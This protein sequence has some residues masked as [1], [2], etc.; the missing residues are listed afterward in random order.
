[1]GN[2]HAQYVI[3]NSGWSAIKNDIYSAAEAVIG[4]QIG[5]IFTGCSGPNL[6]LDVVL[7]AETVILPE[8]LP[9]VV[10]VVVISSFLEQAISTDTATAPAIKRKVFFI[11][12]RVFKFFDEAKVVQE[13][14][15]LQA[16]SM[17][18]TIL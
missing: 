10:V 2:G 14:L 16:K 3:T 18:S 1:M 11:V 4:K 9:V 13:V 6:L 7:A 12:I 15:R 5:G 8:E 17:K